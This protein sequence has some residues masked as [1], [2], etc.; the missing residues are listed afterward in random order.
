VARAPWLLALAML[1]SCGARTG[2]E[3]PPPCDTAAD[4]AAPSDRCG[5]LAACIR[6]RCGFVAP[7]ACTDDTVCTDDVCDARTGACEHTIRDRDED[8]FADGSCGGDDCDDHDPLIHPG[9]IERCSAGVDDDCDGHIDCS[10]TDCADDPRCAM[11]SRE[12]CTGGI[13]EDCDGQLDCVDL[14]CLGSPECCTETI[15]V[16]CDDARDDDCDGDV[17][18]IDLDCAHAPTCCTPIA[19]S[20]NG[21]DDDCDGT[22]DDGVPCFTLDGAPLEALAATTCGARWYAYDSP[23][24]ASAHPIPDLRM[25]GRAAIAVTSAP[26][27]AGVVVIADQVRDGTG[28]M[29]VAEFQLEPRTSGGVTVSDD[30]G[31]CVYD[32]RSG[33]G[34]CTWTWQPCCT[35]GVMLGD[36]TEDFCATVTLTPMDGIA[37]S[38][39]FDGEDRTIARALGAPFTIC[40]TTI[41]AVP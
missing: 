24:S 11:C 6:G 31:E 2:L 37:S 7:P 13:D 22:I 28:G 10:D 8:G 21:L 19:E 38:V 26:C 32:A 9:A 14:D 3:Q 29:M 23:D 18:C 40:G 16:L 36:F 20:C 35:D 39:V 27:G 30:P 34:S 1:A 33:R 4:C 5:S 41:P 12:L 25:S 17:D 15:E